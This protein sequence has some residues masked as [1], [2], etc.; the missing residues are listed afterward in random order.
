MDI[1]KVLIFPASNRPHHRSS[2]A[3]NSSRAG[4]RQ[5]L[6]DGFT[7][8]ERWQPYIKLHGSYNWRTNAD[9]LLITGGAKSAEIAKVPLLTWYHQQFRTMITQP[10]AKLMIIGYGFGDDHINKHLEAATRSGA[11]FFIVDLKGIDII[12]KR[13]PRYRLTQPPD[14]LFNCLRDSMVGASRRPFRETLSRDPVELKKFV[15][16]LELKI[17]WLYD[18]EAPPDSS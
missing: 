11:K 4:V 12:D 8:K 17:K 7:L 18:A 10:N 16:F 9:I 5:V 3:I 6:G 2:M 1:G 13:G 14:E 15:D